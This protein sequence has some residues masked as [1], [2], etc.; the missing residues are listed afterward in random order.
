MGLGSKGFKEIWNVKLGRMQGNVIVVYLKLIFQHLHDE[1]EKNQEHCHG[2][3]G[4]KVSD[5]SG[6]IPLGFYSVLL[7]GYTMCLNKY[8]DCDQNT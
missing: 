1:N 3:W 6:Y 5:Y 7:D 4:F 8:Y 2:I